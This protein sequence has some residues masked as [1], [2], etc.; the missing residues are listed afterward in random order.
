MWLEE[1]TDTRILKEGTKLYHKSDE[2]I[3]FFEAIETCFFTDDRG[4]GHCY[5]VTLTDDITVDYY[6]EE[7]VRFT[8]DFTNCKAEYVGF[9]GRNKENGYKY[10]DSRDFNKPISIDIEA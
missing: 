6:D 3:D 5:I 9:A 7:E 2:L 1:Q 8:P 4:E 10:T